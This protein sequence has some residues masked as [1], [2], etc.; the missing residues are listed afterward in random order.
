MTEIFNAKKCGAIIAIIV[1]GLLST[2]ILHKISGA[3]P[4]VGGME[5]AA[6]TAAPPDIDLNLVIPIYLGID[7]ENWQILNV[8]QYDKILPNAVNGH[9]NQKW[10]NDGKTGDSNLTMWTINLVRAK[11]DATTG[12]KTG[13]PCGGLIAVKMVTK[14]E[15]LHMQN[16]YDADGY[17]MFLKGIIRNIIVIPVSSPNIDIFDIEDVINQAISK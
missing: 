9:E 6:P 7:N 11:E 13:R 15:F 8:F 1:I 16:Q 10:Y 14:S 17:T 5:V 4:R 2:I 12:C 3:I